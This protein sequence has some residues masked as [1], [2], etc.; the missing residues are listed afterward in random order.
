MAWLLDYFL[1]RRSSRAAT[2]ALIPW[3]LLALP[4][5]WKARE[6]QPVTEMFVPLWARPLIALDALAFYLGKLVWPVGLWPDTRER[7]NGCCNRA[8]LTGPGLCRPLRLRSCGGLLDV[9]DRM[10]L[11]A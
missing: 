6:A 1:L 11:P 8:T 3:M 2:T 5:M 9:A 4:I 7:R 10:L